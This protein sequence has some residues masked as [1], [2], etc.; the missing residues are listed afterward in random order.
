MIMVFPEGSPQG[1]SQL[2]SLG[3]E[4]EWLRDAVKYGLGYASE[5]T[6]NDPSSSQST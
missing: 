2:F 4:E 5:C 1:M 3:L 6:A